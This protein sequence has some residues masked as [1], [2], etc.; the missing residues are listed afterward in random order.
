M[1]RLPLTQ[2]QDGRRR[3]LV[4]YRGVSAWWATSAANAVVTPPMTATWVISMGPIRAVRPR[5]WRWQGR[6]GVP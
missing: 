4:G 1:A 3:M 2:V 6:P 5:W